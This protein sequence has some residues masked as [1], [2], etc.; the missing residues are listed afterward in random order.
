MDVCL[1]EG[2]ARGAASGLGVMRDRAMAKV[3]GMRILEHVTEEVGGGAKEGRLMGEVWSFF[4]RVV[5][6]EERGLARRGSSEVVNGNGGGEVGF[7]GRMLGNDDPLPLPPTTTTTP[8]TTTPP[9]TPLPDITNL[10][11]SAVTKYKMTI[12]SLLESTSHPSELIF[13]IVERTRA[14]GEEI[15]GRRILRE[16]SKYAEEEGTR[17]PWLKKLV[18]ESGLG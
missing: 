4:K 11:V 2:D 18:G 15:K 7:F 9:Q 1:R 14:E 10:P 5:E 16:W 3:K 12:M 17:D 8:I 13:C 6:A